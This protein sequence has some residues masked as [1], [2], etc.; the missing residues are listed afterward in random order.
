MLL[1][2]IKTA[3]KV[4]FASVYLSPKQVSLQRT[5]EVGRMS[6]PHHFFSILYDP[7]IV[8]GIVISIIHIFVLQLYGVYKIKNITFD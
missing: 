3:L 5:E 4:I 7:S 2:R 8:N 1:I 6:K